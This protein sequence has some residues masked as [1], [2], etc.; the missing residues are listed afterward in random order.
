MSDYR[1]RRRQRLEL[2]R[3]LAESNRRHGRLMARLNEIADRRQAVARRTTAQQLQDAGLT[4]AARDRQAEGGLSVAA[5]MEAAGMV[6]APAAERAEAA[7]LEHAARRRRADAET[8]RRERLYAT[9]RDI[10]G[11]DEAGRMVR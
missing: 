7:R 9:L 1:E 4:Y 6:F 2:M 10:Y 8:T 3:Q 5:S 11:A